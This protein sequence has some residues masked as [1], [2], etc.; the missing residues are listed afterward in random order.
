V[1]QPDSW[2]VQAGSLLVE[3]GH[4]EIHNMMTTQLS[5]SVA[6]GYM[7]LTWPGGLASAT[8]A[9]ADV[10]SSVLECASLVASAAI[11][12]I[13]NWLNLA[14]QYLQHTIRHAQGLAV[15]LSRCHLLTCKGF[16]CTHYAI[17]HTHQPP[18]SVASKAVVVTSWYNPSACHG[19]LTQP[20][21]H[22]PGPDLP[23][24]FQQSVMSG[25]SITTLVCV[26]HIV[27][28]AFS[29]YISNQ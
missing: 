10:L 21:C 1:V 25:A 29:W 4:P 6:T 15:C 22:G 2:M 18:G 16:N 24:W 28:D 20:E 9:A 23:P 11:T 5:V 17:Q 7:R 13:G 14:L 8:A 26:I 19:F 27:V 3:R 12:C